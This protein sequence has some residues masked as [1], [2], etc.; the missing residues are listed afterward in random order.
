MKFSGSSNPANPLRSLLVMLISLLFSGT[1]VDIG[2]GQTERN[3]IITYTPNQTWTSTTTLPTSTKEQSRKSKQFFDGLGRPLQ[4]VAVESSPA[5]NDV[6]QS[7]AYDAFGRQYITYLPF[8]TGAGNNG[9][10]HED[11]TNPLNWNAYYGSTEDDYAFAQTKFEDSPLNRPIEQGAP[12]QD[13][14]LGGGH[15]I[16]SSYETN[17]ANQVFRWYVDYTSYLPETVGGAYYPAD[18]LYKNITIDEEGHQVVEFQ[19]KRGRTVLKKVQTAFNPSQTSHIGWTNTYYVY[20]DYDNLIFV[21]PPKLVDDIHSSVTSN[22]TVHNSRIQ[23]LAFQ[24]KYDSRQRL[25]EKRVPGSQWV[26]LVYDDRDRLVMTQD[27]NQRSASLGTPRNWTVTK[28]DALNRPAITGIYT[29]GTV[30]DQSTM[31][32][33]I[34]T[35]NFS[36]SYDGS[37][38]FYGYTNTVWPT[39]DVEVLTVNYYDDYN[40]LS[41][42]GF[43]LPDNDFDYQNP[44]TPYEFTNFPTVKGQITG[45]Q[46]KILGSDRFLR[47]VSYY[48]DRYRPIQLI[49]ENHKGTID[50]ISNHFDFI[51]NL[52]KSRSDHWKAYDVVWT[53]LVYTTAYANDLVRDSGT[54]WSAG[55]GSENILP[56]GEDGWVEMVVSEGYKRRMIGLSEVIGSGYWTSIDYAIYLNSNLIAQVRESGSGSKATTPF[57]E[58]DVLRVERI[59]NTVY[60]KKNGS[61]F[62]TSTIS[63]STQL[64]V[65]ASLYNDGASIDDAYASFG[66]PNEEDLALTLTYRTYNYDHMGRLLDVRH[67]IN[68]QSE[69]MLAESSYNELGELKEKDLHSLDNGATRKQSVDYRYN[70]RG[71]LTSINNA[72]LIQNS[73][74]N[75]SDDFYGMEIGYHN[76]LP[77]MASIAAHNGNIS[78]IKYSIKNSSEGIHEVGY[79]FTYDRLN[80]ITLAD[81]RS[82]ASGSWTDVAKYTVEGI[83]YDLN[84][85]ITG[86][87]RKSDSGGNMDV[88]SYNYDSGTNYSNQLHY[89]NDSGDANEGFKNGNTGTDD[90]TYD[91]NGNMNQDLNKGITD[92]VYNYLNLPQKVTFDAIKY[93]NYYY[94][95]GGIKVRQEVFE[96]GVV[97]KITDYMG[98][99]IQEDNLITQISHDEGRL[100]PDRNGQNEVLS[101]QYQYHL[102][103]HLGN[104]RVTFGD[105]D[106]DSYTATMETDVQSTQDLE[107][108]I[109]SNMDTR[110]INSLANATQPVGDEVS[111]LNNTQPVG[112]AISLKVYPG[113]AI[114]MD[115]WAYYTSSSGYGNQISQTTWINELA[116][117]FGGVNG[118]AGEA[119]AIY[120]GINAIGAALFGGSNGSSVPAAYLNYILFDE[121]F[122]Q[123]PG[124]MGFV[125]VTSAAL[126][127]KE[128]LIQSTLNIDHTGYIFIY[129]SNESNS[130]N[131][132]FFDDLTVVRTE[133]EIKQETHY[134]PFGLTQNAIGKQGN[135]PFKY[136]GK[137]DQD[138]LDLG[139]MDYGW[140]MLDPA[141]ARFQKVDRF[142]EGYYDNNPYHYALNNPIKFIDIDGDTTKLIGWNN[143]VQDFNNNFYAGVDARMKD[144]SV[145]LNDLDQ[146]AGDLLQTGWDVSFGLLSSNNKTEQTL[147][148]AL[149]SSVDTALEFP[150]MSEEDKGTVM[151][152]FFTFI[153]KSAAER[154]LPKVGKFEIGE[155][156]DLKKRSGVGDGLDV[157]HVPQKHAANQLI[158]NYDPQTGSAI[159]VPQTMHR[160][161]PTKKGNVQGTA[162]QQL[163]KDARDL[164]N[165]G[166][167]NNKVQQMINFVKQKYKNAFQKN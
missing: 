84:G 136:N 39:S 78:S 75:D 48:D 15:T 122:N 58:G 151:A 34:S 153:M 3:H 116:S 167:P 32:G 138:E 5:G 132:V 119:G 63:S 101:Y 133:G 130:S 107:E 89:V 161:I 152:A 40:F 61:T 33:L 35:T 52:L 64:V 68:G 156:K 154:K 23:N 91:A 21:L 46:T 155:F 87:T 67:Q 43:D 66:I 29:H 164:R 24:Y 86:L 51:G 113:D 117:S 80:R 115:V 99:T 162:R 129:V 59:N 128:N 7:V 36:E 126:N 60:Y 12:G 157:H 139:W 110:V 88:L 108:A 20:D 102:T 57:Q 106:V 121:D 105:E 112:P 74:N 94:D 144:P 18:E 163:A 98:E 135:N 92:I 19:N 53:S 62:Y 90:Y 82:K 134:Y 93:I 97:A 65:D 47:S 137:E 146:I 140:R 13:W 41:L 142:A 10:Y 69:V 95:A 49:T 77:G 124:G 118:G 145:L 22:Y 73:L 14:E 45:S 30:V 9:Q 81:Y 6:I 103:D 17:V 54:S 85:N 104:V 114:D 109:F 143:Y 158:E 28:Y 16:Q 83:T 2:Y 125:S 165:A 1:I 56:A 71:W 27:G 150:G 70:I 148:S 37:T 25:V 100:M 31:A 26:Y 160:G 4:T 8:A 79:K 50:R 55:A 38:G 120:D 166:V 131:W 147:E 76:N 127:N 159:T 72:G 149:T 123:I 11:A 44:G 111:R 96:D 42:Q 141:I